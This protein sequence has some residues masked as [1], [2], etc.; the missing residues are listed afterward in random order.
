MPP[1]S[2]PPEAPSERGQ[3]YCFQSNSHPRGASA[4]LVY[5]R[6][7]VP[8]LAATLVP[9]MLLA[10]AAVLMGGRIWPHFFWMAPPAL[11]LSWGWARFQLGRVIAEVC[12][13]PGQGAAA[14]RSI[15][16]VLAGT[17]PQWHR[18]ARLR[19]ERRALRLDLGDTSY[20][21]LL[22]RWEQAEDLRNALRQTVQ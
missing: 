20:R 8:P 22:D 5:S 16:E 15:H 2:T 7:M 1:A 18:A 9:L 17:T 21:L 14:V 11:A 6:A 3:Q 10:L 12:V 13:R 19:L 4:A